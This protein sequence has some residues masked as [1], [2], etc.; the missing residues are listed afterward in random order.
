MYFLKLIIFA[1]IFEFLSCLG[2]E[3]V[4]NLPDPSEKLSYSLKDAIT[5]TTENYKE[6]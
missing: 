1:I 5:N 3:S 2:I 6:V 4:N